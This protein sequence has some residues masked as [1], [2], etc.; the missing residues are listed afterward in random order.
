MVEL[1]QKPASYALL[2]IG[3]ERSWGAPRHLVQAHMTWQQQLGQECITA[4][5]G[6]E[7]V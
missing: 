3:Y 7:C 1:T 2:F 6:H 4:K 5:L